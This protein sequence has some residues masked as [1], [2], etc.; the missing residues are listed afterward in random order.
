MCAEG[1][2]GDAAAADLMDCERVAVPGGFEEI[3]GLLA[4]DDRRALIEGIDASL[5]GGLKPDQLSLAFV[6]PSSGNDPHSAL[7]FA[8]CCLACRG[9][10]PAASVEAA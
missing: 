7:A 9:G 3:D 8:A 6:P 1:F 10:M 4:A 2:Q 5:L